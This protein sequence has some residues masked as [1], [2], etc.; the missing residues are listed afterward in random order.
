M[1]QGEIAIRE[2]SSE[3]GR[4]IKIA[5][6]GNLIGLESPAGYE[7]IAAQGAREGFV[8]SY[9]DPNGII[10]ILHDVFD[11][12]SSSFKQGLRDFVLVSFT[13][14][15]STGDL[16]VNTL[17]STKSVLDTRDGLLRLENEI[18]WKAGTGT[19][20]IRMTVINKS[21]T[22]VRV[23][24]LKRVAD[25]NAGAD[26]QNTSFGLTDSVVYFKPVCTCRPP[27]PPGPWIPLV[28]FSGTNA[29]AL[30]V[31]A[32]DDSELVSV[33]PGPSLIGRQLDTDTQGVLVFKA[34]GPLPPGGMM[35]AT[36]THDVR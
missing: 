10:R 4:R 1:A 30:N 15:P 24:N 35:N 22:T 32:S 2:Y 19:V 27:I 28:F 36:V 23:L 3:N 9:I 29:V 26:T 34:D 6:T 18:T 20:N 13:A 31:L 33:G 21:A 12:H 11:T 5:A 25:V 17:I 16:A 8:I 14:P 7:N